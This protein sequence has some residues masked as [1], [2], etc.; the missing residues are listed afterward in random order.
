[1][2][3]IENN[4]LL[5]KIQKTYREVKIEAFN[6]TFPTIKETILNT[7]LILFLASILCLY[8]LFIGKITIICLRFIGAGA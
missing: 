1:M 5:N 2:K 3:N 7:L 4:N 6:L 8:F